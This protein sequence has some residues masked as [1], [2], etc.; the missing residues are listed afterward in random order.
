MMCNFNIFEGIITFAIENSSTLST[1]V[2]V[3]VWLRSA[4]YM[5]V[6]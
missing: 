4:H 5:T 3:L 1:D 6:T 2:Q